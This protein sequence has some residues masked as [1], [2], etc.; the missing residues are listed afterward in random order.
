[1]PGRVFRT[2]QAARSSGFTWTVCS[3]TGPFS[4]VV[5]IIIGTLYL[6]S[7]P[8]HCACAV[9]RRFIAISSP[10]LEH[11]LEQVQEGRRT[12]THERHRTI[13]LGGVIPPRP[14]VREPSAPAHRGFPSQ[15]R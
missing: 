4:R 1:M 9:F 14:L 13:R 3:E 2:V 12:T 8:F 7:L 5:G 10:F 11:E 15:H 6:F